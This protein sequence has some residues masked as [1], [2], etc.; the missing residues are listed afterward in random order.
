VGGSWYVLLEG[1]AALIQR[2]HPEIAITVVEGGGVENHSLIGTGRL[3]MGVINPPM[4][5]AALAGTP[6]YDRAYTDLRVGISNLTTNHLQFMVAREVPI[7]SLGDWAERRYPLRIPVDRVGTVDRLVFDLALQ[8]SGIA[9]S[10]LVTWGGELVPAANYGE[11]LALY[12]SGRVDALWQFMGIPSPSILAAHA[13]RPLKALPLPERL[14][15]ELATRGWSPAKLPSKAY[16]MIEAPVTTVSM[17]TSL[18]FHASVSE[19]V[20]FSIVEAICE[21]PGSVHEIHEAAARFDPSE[22][23]HNSG[24]PLHAGAERY[25]QRKRLL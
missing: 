18:G 15:Q 24:G 6:P 17:G 10:D 13:H 5:V 20:V 4:T 22:S 21:H 9:E 7:L 23:S 1:L 25:Y 19:D 14:V 8:S 11:Q 2:I 3:P 12:R 16:D